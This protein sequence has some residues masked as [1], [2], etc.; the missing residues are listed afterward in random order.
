M[1]DDI[2]A[3]DDAA[4]CCHA[5]LEVRAAAGDTEAAGLLSRR[6]TIFWTEVNY[7]LAMFFTLEELGA[8]LKECIIDYDYGR[9][10]DAD[11]EIIFNLPNVEV[12]KWLAENDAEFDNLAWGESSAYLP[13]GWTLTRGADQ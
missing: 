12:P 11:R 8:D 1:T 4:A 10:S 9:F 2:Y 7:E 13:E 5:P 3:N 6:V